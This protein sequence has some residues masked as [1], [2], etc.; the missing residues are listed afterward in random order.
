[1]QEQTK[2]DLDGEIMQ[3]ERLKMHQMITDRL[4]HTVD[5]KKHLFASM[6]HA[7]VSCRVM[8]GNLQYADIDLLQCQYLMRAKRAALPV[9]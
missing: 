9:A 6:C 8:Q 5:T 7:A 1:M 2:Q 4:I 3:I